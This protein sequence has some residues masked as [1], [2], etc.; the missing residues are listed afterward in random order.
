M[1]LALVSLLALLFVAA[2]DAGGDV[3]GPSNTTLS[4]VTGSVD[5]GSEVVRIDYTLRSAG[6][7]A[8]LGTLELS[9]FRWD[10]K[11]GTLEK[12]ELNRI[13]RRSLFLPT[14]VYTVEVVGRNEF[15][16]VICVD[17]TA[18]ETAEDLP[19]DVYRL[20][21]CAAPLDPTG[22]AILTVV[23]PE[24]SEDDG[25]I[26]FLADIWCGEDPN[27][28]DIFYT[29]GLAPAGETPDLFAREATADLG[30]GTVETSVWN[31]RLFELPA[32][33]CRVDI[34]RRPLSSDRSCTAEVN[35][36]VVADAV[37]P[38]T[39]VLPCVD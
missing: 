26:P 5:L 4:V 31:G 23:S 32:G 24:G 27:D 30:S 10:A 8:R 22:D 19:A 25:S 11:P 35:F 36:T 18:F 1:R 21:S 3:D 16:E 33:N 6:S 15:G 12:G 39:F 14:D 17:E 7:S 38:V 2:C 20:M 37:T 34:E 28:P 9:A 29:I 13:W